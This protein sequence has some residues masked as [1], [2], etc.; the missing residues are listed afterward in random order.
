MLPLNTMRGNTRLTSRRLTPEGG[1][2]YQGENHRI[3]VSI[4][5]PRAVNRPE[6]HAALSQPMASPPV[7]V[8]STSPGLGPSLPGIKVA[9]DPTPGP[10]RLAEVPTMG[11]YCTRGTFYAPTEHSQSQTPPPP[12]SVISGVSS[13]V[14]TVR[15]ISNTTDV[16]RSPSV[17]DR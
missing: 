8:T 12:F 11:T 14:E 6:P 13:F 2:L 4:P 7:L 5:K 1:A 17:L 10:I 3:P 16:L 15:Q 9:C